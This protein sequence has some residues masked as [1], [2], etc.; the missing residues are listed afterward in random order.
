M[1]QQDIDTVAPGCGAQ[2]FAVDRVYSGTTIAFSAPRALCARRSPRNPALDV[3]G[4]AHYANVRNR[5]F[6]RR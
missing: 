5:A 3:D 6:R 4:T 2:G 1:A